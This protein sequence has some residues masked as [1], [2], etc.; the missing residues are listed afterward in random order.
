[1][2]TCTHT[3]T[4]KDVLCRHPQER[5][6][7]V[8]FACFVP[9]KRSI[10]YI[11]TCARTVYMYMQSSHPPCPSQS[12]APALEACLHKKTHTDT[13]HVCMPMHMIHC[14]ESQSACIFH[15]PSKVNFDLLR[16]A[17]RHILHLWYVVLLG[18]AAFSYK[19]IVCCPFARRAASLM[20]VCV[21]YEY[22]YLNW[23][24]TRHTYL[25][26]YMHV[27]IGFLVI[28]SL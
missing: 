5:I 12:L 17:R 22:V 13:I 25:C 18:Y 9:K 16:G 7:H 8:F 3:H 27:C 20:C 28:Q 21:L 23:S 4:H 19:H 11:R 6:A 24:Q 10:L 15:L 1:M 26:A 14:P 2:H